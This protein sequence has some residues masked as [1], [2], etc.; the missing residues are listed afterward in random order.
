MCKSKS[1]RLCYWQVF[2][3]NRNRHANYNTLLLYIAQKVCLEHVQIKCLQKLK[4]KCEFG[5]AA[6]LLPSNLH[7]NSRKSYVIDIFIRIIIT[8]T[9]D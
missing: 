1:T 7:N 5:K 6:P 3:F 4:A 9:S 8:G 2:T